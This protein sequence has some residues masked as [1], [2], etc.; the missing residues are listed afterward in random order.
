MIRKLLVILS[1]IVAASASYATVYFQND[2]TKEGWPNYP[3]TPEA[4]GTISD[5]TSP[6]YQGTNAIEFTQTWLANYTGRYHSEVDYQNTQG[7]GDDR[8]YGMTVYLP[9]NWVYTNSNVCIQQWAGDGPWLMMEIRGDE[10][11]VLPHIAGIQNLATLPKGQW[12]RIVTRLLSSSNGVFQAWV[13][14]VQVMNLSG[15][16]TPPSTTD[17]VRWSAGAYVTGWYGVTTQ[18]TPDFI[19]LYQDHY[20][21]ASSEAE[22]EPTN[23]LEDGVFSGKY[24]IENVSSGLSLN[25][26]NNITGNGA[27][28]I[29]WSYSGGSNELWNFTPTTNGYYQIVSVLSGRDAVVQGASTAN[30]AGIVQWSFGSSGDDQWEPVANSDGSYTFYNLKSGKV[31]EDPDSSASKGTQMDQW[32]SNRGNNQKWDLISQ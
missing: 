26:S 24:Q 18:P 2:G 13:N 3:Q 8:Y 14:G 21:I 1:L 32:S 5:V 6:T 27:C 4:D 28:I 12:V 17:E 29:Q 9:S 30:G 11:V 15:N 23:W 22:A 7:Y 31:L 10:L 16:F 19:E 20:R 25:V